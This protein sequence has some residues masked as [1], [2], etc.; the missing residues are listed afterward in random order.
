MNRCGLKKEKYVNYLK[1]ILRFILYVKIRLEDTRSNL[2]ITVRRQ[3]EI[4]GT[5][6]ATSHK[7]IYTHACTLKIIV[8]FVNFN[9]F[10][11]KTP[12]L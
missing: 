7:S 2:E 12:F 1:S 5:I 6:S 10:V 9:P 8:V 11:P 4:S 3:S